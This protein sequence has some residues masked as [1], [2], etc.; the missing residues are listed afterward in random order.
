MRKFLIV[1]LCTASVNTELLAQSC[2][3]SLIM[4]KKNPWKFEKMQSTSSVTT[5]PA[6][7]FPAIF[8]NTDTYG[9]MFMEIYPEA[10]G[11]IVKGVGYINEPSDYIIKGIAPYRYTVSFNPYWCNKTKNDQLITD[12]KYLTVSNAEVQANN[13]MSIMQMLP[14]EYQ[15][16]GKP[17]RLFRLSKT[18]GEL[19][20]FKLFEGNGFGNA[21]AILFTHDNKLPYRILTRKEYLELTRDYWVREMEKT[22]ALIGGAEKEI[23]DMIEKTK[24]EYSGEM[25]DMMLKELN[26]QLV[27]VRKQS[28]ANMDNFK[29]DNYSEID[30]IDNYLKNASAAALLQPA[31]PVATGVHRGFTTEKNGGNLIVVIDESYFKKS[32]P[33]HAAQFLIFYWYYIDGSVGSLYLKEILE[34]KFSLERLKS[35][36]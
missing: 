1:L 28:K 14:E 18:K 23:L 25:R 2:S 4:T 27:E 31:I 15:W 7:A 12:P 11:G 5:A 32:L 19:N 30:S 13:L 21:S 33:V 3:D 29:K 10:K 35:M 22:K 20:G 16:N 36:S 24:K 8:K 6:S 26:T 17:I 9:K 34:K